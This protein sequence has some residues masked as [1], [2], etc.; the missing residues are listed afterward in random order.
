MNECQNLVYIHA[1]YYVCDSMLSAQYTSQATL[2]KAES[3]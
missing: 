3:N 1:I 2:Q